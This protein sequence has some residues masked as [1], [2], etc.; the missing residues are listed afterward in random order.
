LL[1]EA[2]VRDPTLKSRFP[3][4][5]A[6]QGETTD[7]LITFI[8]DRPGHDRRYALD[9]SK[10]MT[11]LGYQPQESFATGLRK[12]IQ[13]Y[14]DHQAWW[15]GVIDGS[16]RVWMQQQYGAHAAVGCG[17]EPRAGVPHQ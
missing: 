10:V 1:D 8:T 2:F 14:L 13:W 6:A 4:A 11:D 12:T 5:P 7:R 17:H 9:A 3:N 16:Y 15:R